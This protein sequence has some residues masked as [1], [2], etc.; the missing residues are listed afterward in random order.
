MAND[1][2][3]QSSSR[4]KFLKTSAVGVSLGL[5]GCS[6]ENG[7]STGDGQSGGGSTT[8]SDG[9][10]GGG[11]TT[12]RSDRPKLTFAQAPVGIFAMTAQHLR[13]TGLLEQ[14]MDEAGYDYELRETW[15]GPTLYASNNVDLFQGNPMEAVR[16]ADAQGI[17]S[18]TFGK[19]MRFID[20]IHMDA[21]A[22][23][24]IRETGSAKATMQALAED[25][26][27]FGFAGWQSGDIPFHIRLL[28]EWGIPFGP[29]AD[30]PFQMQNTSNESVA[31]LLV[32][33]DVTIGNIG[34]HIPG[35][36]E[37]ILP[38]IKI[39][40]VYTIAEMATEVGYEAPLMF[41][42]FT[43]RQ[44]S[45]EEHRE[46]YVAFAKAMKEAFQFRKEE[47]EKIKQWD[48]IKD[49][50]GQKT[51][52][53]NSFYIDWM[54]GKDLSAKYGEKY[55]LWEHDRGYWTNPY[56]TDEIIAA[57]KKF[58]DDSVDLGY[59]MKDWRDYVEMKQVDEIK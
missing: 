56:L 24:T 4:R 43:C 12:S 33:G 32:R 20:G 59:M 37:Q 8:S 36:V 22:D 21:S 19:T 54:D 14:Y 7:Q 57:H 47:A 51:D 16:L 50:T 35:Y 53:Q 46:G 11:N 1:T 48:N 9:Q 15:D 58:I 41:N 44:E 45:F 52:R 23:H 42:S 2:K 26:A 55:E 10:S 5:A 31:Q 34:P 13:D 29:D 17:K 18:T 38:E 25:N 30:T 3:G 39:L 28:N 27:V 49:F 40:P 6:A